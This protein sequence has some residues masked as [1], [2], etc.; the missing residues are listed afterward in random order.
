MRRWIKRLAWFLVVVTL[1]GAA[2]FYAA[3]SAIRWY[4]HDNYAGIVVNGEI[5]IAWR[6]AEVVFREVSVD[7][8][9]LKGQLKRVEVN[10]DK[11]VHVEGGKLSIDLDRFGQSGGGDDGGSSTTVFA[12]GLTVEV[13]K[14]STQA[15]IE[16]AT[17]NP[18]QVCFKSGRIKY[19]GF[20]A[21]VLAGCLTR[22]YQARS[23]NRDKAEFQASRVE[24]PVELPLNVPRM[25]RKQTIVVTELKMDLIDKVVRFGSAGVEGVTAVTGTIKLTDETVLFDAVQVDVN[26]PWVSPAPAHF[27]RVA[28]TAP[29]DLFRGK[30]GKLRIMLDRAI[31]R[32]DPLNWTIE[33]DEPCNDWVGAMPRPLPEA[34]EQAEGKFEGN[35][36]FDVRAKPTPHLE[37]DYD[38]KFRCSEEPLKSLKRSKFSYFAYDSKGGLFERETGYQTPNWVSLADLPPHVPEA[39]RLMED[40]GF[41]SHNGIHV[42]ALYNSLKANLEKGRFVKGGSTITMQLAKNLWLKRHKTVGR[43]A[44]EALLTIALESCLSKAEIMELYMNVVEYGPD[45]YGLRAASR[46]YFHKDPSA[47]TAD[48]AFYMASILP[49]PKKALYPKYGGMAR[50]KRLMQRLANVGAISE[51]LVPVEGGAVDTTGWDSLE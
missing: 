43:K 37:I 36:R 32:I 31:V 51:Y 11:V 8:P 12:A 16:K 1:V 29:L 41:H 28:V 22:T 26:H 23:G 4:V 20:E 47:L 35:L 14:G 7:R 50:T 19:R 34:L 6:K 33:G 13:R 46:H 18:Q 25:K 42:M 27:N 2:G 5:E 17:V 30:A 21:V 49:A 40:P 3:P 44:Q 48:E 24:V 38:C 9:G 10:R 39:F 15:M 45:I